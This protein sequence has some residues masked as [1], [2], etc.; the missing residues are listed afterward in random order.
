LPFEGDPAFES[1]TL[2]NVLEELKGRRVIPALWTRQ[3]LYESRAVAADLARLRSFYISH[4]YFDARV[5]VGGLTVEGRAAILTLN[6][7][8]GPKY[9]ARQVEIDGIDREVVQAVV[10]AGGEF[11]GG[12]LC[13]CLLDAR[14]IAEAHGQ[15]DFAAEIDARRCR[16]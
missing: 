16:S 11:R 4:G 8:S 5:E 15:L 12:S 14:R 13:T 2:K 7:Q 6:V 3:P 1:E 10:G 9:S